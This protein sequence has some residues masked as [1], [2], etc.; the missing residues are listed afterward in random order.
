MALASLDAIADGGINDHVGGGFHRYTV[1]GD[2]RLPHFKKML[3]DQATMVDAFL[4]AGEPDKKV[5]KEKL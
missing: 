5:A 4:E 1:D 2:W 3:H